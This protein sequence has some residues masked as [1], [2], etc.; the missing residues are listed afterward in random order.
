MGQITIS[1]N[2]RSYR[3]ACGDGEETRLTELA[4]Y[5]GERVSE[6]ATEFSQVGD[7]RLI[8]MAA[9]MITDE[10][11]DAREALQQLPP[12]AIRPQNDGMHQ[13]GFGSPGDFFAAPLPEADAASPAGSADE[14]MA[15]ANL[16]APPRTPV[17]RRDTRRSDG[18]ASL[19]ERLAEA[20]NKAHTHVRLA[21]RK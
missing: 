10:L 5:V 19:E 14:E 3:L 6:L 11:F 8:V 1:L 4:A 15:S 17:A 13:A 2:G 20:R 7:D 12:G 16:S 9:L 18:R 21:D